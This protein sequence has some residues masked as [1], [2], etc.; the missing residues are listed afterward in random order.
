MGSVAA[1][2]ELYKDLVQV[3]QDPDREEFG[4]QG[5]QRTARRFS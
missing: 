4:D 5:K 2:R 3:F 1:M